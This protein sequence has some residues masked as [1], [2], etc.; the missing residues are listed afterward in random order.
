MGFVLCGGGMPE[1]MYHRIAEK[2]CLKI[3][4]GELA[5]GDQLPTE[6][7]LGEQYAASRNTIRD[8]VS[9]LTS[10]GLVEK[11]RVQGTF[12]TGKNDP[13]ITTLSE[14]PETGFGGGEGI[15]YL[16]EVTA[17]RRA[18]RASQPRVEVRLAEGEIA[19]ELRLDKNTPVVSR[20]QQRYID[21]LPWSLQTS[22]YPMRLVERG[23]LQLL[24]PTYI[25]PGV[26]SYLKQAVG[27][28]Q[29]GYRDRIT[30][31]PPGKAE[32]GFFGL[33]DDGRVAVFVTFRTAFDSG[34]ESFRLTV[35]VFPADRNEFVI[36]V[37]DVPALA[38]AGAAGSHGEVP[39]RGG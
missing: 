35:S 15:A 2:L 13:F 31:R 22:F 30:V 3:E 39:L 25:E 28:A 36:N 16:T 23:A 24:Q 21:D 7:R 1:P 8:A 11:R 34:G 27:I 18:P 20:H 9:W 5:P 4:N 38:V 17:S 10:R 14:D 6:R 29:A 26:V 19:T 32:A 12:V 33:P 37:G